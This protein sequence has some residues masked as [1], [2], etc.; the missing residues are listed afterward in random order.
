ME[1]KITP[2]LIR[3][4]WKQFSEYNDAEVIEVVKVFQKEQPAVLSYLLAAGGEPFV[5]DETQMLLFYGTVIWRLMK[6]AGYAEQ[7]V[8]V[9]V[10]DGLQQV[11]VE[12]FANSP[13]GDAELFEQVI[14]LMDGYPEPDLLDTILNLLLHDKDA[15]DDTPH[16]RDQNLGLAFMYLKTVIDAFLAK[17][18]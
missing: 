7:R 5:G 17:S 10:L 12:L 8:P 1:P 14:A 18:A 11:N 13:A 3:E 15:G 4:T 6:Q 16:I 2:A 9:P